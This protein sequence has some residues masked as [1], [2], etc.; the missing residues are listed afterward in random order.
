M[1]ATTLQLIFLLSVAKLQT[2]QAA[3]PAADENAA[4]FGVL[5][6][7][8]KAAQTA[9]PNFAISDTVKQI[10]FDAKALN[11]SL[12]APEAA[13][14]L[15][16]N[17]TTDET[18]LK[19]SGIAKKI[20]DEL[21]FGTA[22]AMATRAQELKKTKAYADLSPTALTPAQMHQLQH[23]IALIATTAGNI[24]DLNIKKTVQEATSNLNKA[25]YGS[26]TTDDK[27]KLVD[28]ASHTS[29]DKSCGKIGDNN[30]NSIAGNSLKGDIMCLCG[31][32]GSGG[33]GNVCGS[34][35]PQLTADA[36]SNT[37]L[38]ADWQ[39]LKNWCKPAAATS[40]TAMALMATA[41]S[42]ETYIAASAGK[43]AKA[44]HI[45]GKHHDSAQTACDAKDTDASN[46]GACVYYG[47]KAGSG[48]K[49]Q[50]SWLQH[51]RTA[52]AEIEKANTAYAKGQMLATQLRRLNESLAALAVGTKLKSDQHQATPAPATNEKHK[53]EV[54]DCTNHSTNSTCTKN[55]NCKWEGQ[56]ETDGTCK[57]KTGTENT[58]AGTGEAATEGTA[59]S[60]GCAKHGTKAN[61]EN[62]KTGDKQNCA[63][64]KG[65]EGE[66][67]KDTE[68]C[69]SSSFL[70]NKQFALSVVSAAFVAL[71]F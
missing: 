58:A 3:P 9:M 26:E 31:K 28:A 65:K 55:N 33:D 13:A 32:S 18:K 35:L 46:S 29:R 44:S 45:I 6:N 8:L 71:L 4:P 20:V 5:C 61:C 37:E 17:K 10:A 21:S 57:P 70:L 50:I 67:D 1:A 14:E 22:K 59:A 40:T 56:T 42:A 66:D 12:S 69:R 30:D 25:I 2:G 41:A 63:W 52:A 27:I 19:A 64:R 38:Q 34:E 43:T 16:D 60:S 36:S 24:D 62:D 7:V 51:L 54:S 47:R 48:R 15:A 49:I 68:K 39:R 53:T 23:K 11:L